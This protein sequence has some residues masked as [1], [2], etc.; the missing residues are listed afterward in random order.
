MANKY[1][2]STHKWRSCSVLSPSWEAGWPL[3]GQG[4]TRQQLKRI[5]EE[6]S[7][8]P[9]L[10]AGQP[11][12]LGD[13]LAFPSSPRQ[14]LRLSS[15]FSQEKDFSRQSVNQRPVLSQLL[16]NML[17]VHHFLT[18]PYL[19]L[20]E[21]GTG[22]ER[23]HTGKSSFIMKVQLSRFSPFPSPF[24]RSSPPPHQYQS[25]RH[26]VSLLGKKYCPHAFRIALKM[27]LQGI[28]TGWQSF[29]DGSSLMWG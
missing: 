14:Y 13:T 18:E 21:E 4:A 3:M 12:A 5:V 6:A 9:L 15:F 8:L 23:E 7:L 29:W 10:Q 22:K 16:F 24:R 2:Y 27:S 17:P 11:R 19:A 26:E 28:G 1:G 25:I 20:G